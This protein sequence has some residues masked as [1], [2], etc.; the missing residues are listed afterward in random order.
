M[1]LKSFNL[2]KK[3]FEKNSLFL[4][5]GNNEGFKEETIEKITNNIQKNF[6]DEKDILLNEDVF[7][8]DL[9]SG[10]LFENKK[11]III[12]RATDKSNKIIEKIDNEKLH[13]TQIILNATNLEKKSKL[14]SLF[15][16]DKNLICVPFYPDTSET[17]L[18]LAKSRLNTM[19]IK[20][21]N[22]DLNSIINKCN[23]DRLFLKNELEKLTLYSKNKKQ[24]LPNEINKLVNLTENHDISE[25]INNCLAKNEKK[26]LDILNENN[27]N[28]EDSILIL[29]TFLNK[30]KQLLRLSNEF[31]INKNISKTISLA[32]PPIFW[33]DKIITETQ[34]KKWNSKNLK[35][36]IYKINEIELFAKKNLFISVKI[37]YDLIIDQTKIKTNN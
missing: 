5:Y 6:I 13:D 35:L 27:F 15:E 2:N 32:K 12:R 14:R 8:N 29:R 4:F 21:S 30:V 7:F 23:G 24:I 9:Y 11:I 3:I 28:N 17:L 37:I 33:K 1:I 18:N 31:E 16:K 26:T 19:K 10:S 36:L 34:L 22:Y 20:I 25:L